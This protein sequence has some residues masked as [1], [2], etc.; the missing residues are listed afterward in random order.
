MQRR[1]D[2]TGR[3][4]QRRQLRRIDRAAL[5]G[6]VKADGADE[7][8]GDK[9]RHDGL[10]LG[11]DSLEARDLGVVDRRIRWFRQT[12]R[13]ARSSADTAGYL[14]SSQ[15]QTGR[16]RRCAAERPRRPTRSPRP[17]A[18]RRCGPRLRRASG[19]TRSTRA[20]SPSRTQHVG[21]G[22]AH[23]RGLEQQAAGLGGGR[24]QPLAALQRLVD[25]AQLLGARGWIL[26]KAPDG[27]RAGSTTDNTHS[28]LSIGP[29]DGVSV[30]RQGGGLPT[31]AQRLVDRD[32]AGGG[33]GAV[34]ASASSACSC[35]RSASSTE[36][37]ST[38]PPS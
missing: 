25:V 17:A 26:S 28:T 23:V 4:L 27:R 37:K 8:A 22:A 1:A 30:P 31:A 15:L 32:Q 20:A 21:H 36:R 6:V 7:L 13:P 24:Q 34:L 3:G 5:L 29:I 18:A 9:D 19:F 16:D 10:G 2:D 14:R 35:V 11:T 12:L 33:V 38:M